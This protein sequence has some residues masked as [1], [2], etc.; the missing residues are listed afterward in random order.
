[1]GRAE[2]LQ[3]PLDKWGNRQNSSLN[4]GVGMGTLK[5]EVGEAEDTPS[6]LSSVP[7]AQSTL[8]TLGGTCGFLEL[9]R[10][11]SPASSIPS[12]TLSG[13][14]V[15]DGIMLTSLDHPCQPNITLSLGEPLQNPKPLAPN[16]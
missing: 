6:S 12:G 8:N 16:P 14:P 10:T 11:M 1:M 2:R 9:S 13:I 3:G 15:G 5:E 4:V 7:C